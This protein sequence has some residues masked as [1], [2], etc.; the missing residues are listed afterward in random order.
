MG[1]ILLHNEV[2]LILHVFLLVPHHLIV[3]VVANITIIHCYRFI[4][5]LI[6][7]VNQKLMMRNFKRIT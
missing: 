5:W 7:S 6:K 1:L 2:V 3:I 4:T